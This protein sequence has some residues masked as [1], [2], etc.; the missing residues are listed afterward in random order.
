MLAGSVNTTCVRIESDMSSNVV[1]RGVAFICLLLMSCKFTG[2][3][4]TTVLDCKTPA[5]QVF[6]VFESLI[7]VLNPS[8]VY[9]YM[10]RYLTQWIWYGNALEL[11]SVD[12]VHS[13]FIYCWKGWGEQEKQSGLVNKTTTTFISDDELILWQGCHS[14][15]HHSHSCHIA[16]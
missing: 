9:L 1:F 4:N 14:N 3:G 10:H 6:I 5:E 8:Q 13:P 15:M 12:L 7:H 11:G 16:S 2:T